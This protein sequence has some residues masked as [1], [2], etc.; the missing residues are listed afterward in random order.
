[1]DGTPG[2]K[3]PQLLHT[4]TQESYQLKVETTYIYCAVHSVH[5]QKH[6]LFGY[7]G[8]FCA[9]QPLCY[10]PSPSCP[11]TFDSCTLLARFFLFYLLNV[12]KPSQHSLS[13]AIIHTNHHLLHILILYPINSFDPTNTAQTNHFYHF[14]CLMILNIQHPHFIS[15]Q[16]RNLIIP[17]HMPAFASLDI[18]L[19]FHRH[20]CT[21]CLSCISYPVI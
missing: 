2:S 12:T 5:V 13:H 14:C 19:L 18:C 8:L 7:S 4:A 3:L 21:H 11:L 15:I 9:K 10:I 17:P 16:K 1:M 6:S 20:K